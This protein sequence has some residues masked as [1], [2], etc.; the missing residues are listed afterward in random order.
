M[1]PFLTIPRN[2]TIPEQ[3]TPCTYK[4]TLGRVR[5]IILA[6]RVLH[7]LSVA[8]VIRHAGCT[9]PVLLPS[10]DSP[11]PLHFSTLSHKRH[12]FPKKN[13]TEHKMRV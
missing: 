9:N 1:P 2:T 4:V 5:V 7:I 3:G 13:V 12:D 8:L 11:D 6:V 10:V